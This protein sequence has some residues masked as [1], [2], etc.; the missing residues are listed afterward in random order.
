MTKQTKKGS[1]NCK[2][3]IV[4]IVKLIYVFLYK[5]FGPCFP[6]VNNIKEL[7]FEF[8]KIN[9]SEFYMKLKEVIEKRLKSYQRC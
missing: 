8:H 2:I 3:L 6:T 5:Y 1:F 7:S 4:F 9:V